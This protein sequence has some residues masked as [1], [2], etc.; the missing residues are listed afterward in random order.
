MAYRAWLLRRKFTPVHTVAALLLTCAV[1]CGYKDLLATTRVTAFG[2]EWNVPVFLIYNGAFLALY[3][4]ILIYG[5]GSRPA[6]ENATPRQIRRA[7]IWRSNRRANARFF[8]FVCMGAE[9]IATVVAFGL[10]FPGTSV[11]N[12][13]KG[14]DAAESMIRYMHQLE[15]NSLFFRA[16]TTH[17]QTLNDGALNGYNGVSAFTSSANVNTTEFMKD[18]GYGAKNTYNRYCFEE[19]SPV[20]NLFL[21]LKYMIDRD[22]K[23]KTSEFFEQ[24]HSYEGVSLL[25]NTAYLPLGF[26]AESSLGELNFANGDHSFRFQNQLFGAATGINSEVWH[27]IAG[28]NLM[29]TGNDVTINTSNS[30]GYCSYQDCKSGS[31]VVY[32]YV[33]D[34]DGFLCL[35]LDLPK[36]ND[37]TVSINEVEQ[38]RESISLPQMIAV[39]QVKAGDIIDVRIL[40]DPEEKGTM[41]LEA[42]ILN[43]DRFWEGYRIL[44]AS[45]LELTAFENTFVEGTIRCDRDGLLYTS[46]PQ[47]GNWKVRVDGEYVEPVLVGAC[48]IGVPMTEGEHLVTF[49]YENNAFRWG[50]KI[51]L[52]SALAFAGLIQWYYKPDWKQLFSEQK[53]KWSA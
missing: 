34:Q 45:T 32:S 40:C 13:P 27:R 39:G 36:R 30:G 17:S 14:T 18:L 47:N 10:Y 49:R 2:N 29:I 19:S 1:L 48:M 9:L 20:A 33:A 44:N 35:H 38:Y 22:G 37:Y 12:Y 41:T 26:L 46:I 3:T 51:T 15:K 28:E 6:P 43:S 16:E 23:D 53:K 52:A 11:K 42:A 50:W 25:K 4:V 21:G 24:V 7:R 8:A 5:Q 31:N